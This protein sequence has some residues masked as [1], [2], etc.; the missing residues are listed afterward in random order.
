MLDEGELR[1]GSDFPLQNSNVLTS[2]LY[3][4]W[5]INRLCNAECIHCYTGSGPNVIEKDLLTEKEAIRVARELGDAGVFQVGLSGGEPLLRDDCCH[6]VAELSRSGVSV[7][8]ATNG[9]LF[10]KAGGKELK[11][12]GLESLCISI[13]SHRAEVHDRIRNRP[14]LFDKAVNAIEAALSENIAVVAG[15]SVLKYNWRE[16]R[17]YVEFMKSL[18]IRD[19]NLTSYVAVGRGSLEHDLSR[20]EEREFLYMVNRLSE[21]YAGSMAV[22]WHDCRFALINEKYSFYRFKGCGAANTTCRI[23]ANGDVMPCSTLPIPGGNLKKRSFKEIWQNSE[24]F[25]KIRDRNNIKD[26]SNCGQCVHKEDCGGCRSIAYAYY[27]DPF[28]GNYHCWL[29]DVEPENLFKGND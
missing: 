26:D 7:A 18:G 5:E 28:A 16:I 17:E 2:P 23:A 3:A 29:D 12:A 8:L 10:D 19:V 1:K 11:K 15:F 20:E 25:S 22:M 13:D 27:N 4:V 21:E 14:G 6:I 24:F 9:Y